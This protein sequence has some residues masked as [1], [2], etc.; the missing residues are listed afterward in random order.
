MQRD[1]GNLSYGI[2][3][4]FVKSEVGG[5][6]NTFFTSTKTTIQPIA[7]DTIDL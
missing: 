2:I 7:V 5:G 1:G 4:P 6:G 3:I